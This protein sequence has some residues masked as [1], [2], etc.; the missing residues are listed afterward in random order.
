MCQLRDEYLNV[1]RF[2]SIADA[3]EKIDAWR[4]D[5]N[6]HRP[7]SSFGHLT[8]NECVQKRQEE[9]TSDRRCSSRRQYGNGATS[10]G[11]RL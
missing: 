6:D 8:P 7:Y 11:G 5:Y 3:I 1:M 4:I 9:Q 2:E 10:N